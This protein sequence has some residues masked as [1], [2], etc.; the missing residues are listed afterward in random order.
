MKRQ[1]PKRSLRLK[2]YNN[3]LITTAM[4]LRAGSN[5]IHLEMFAAA[6]EYLE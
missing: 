2:A 4:L 1:F 3:R 5:R 6:V